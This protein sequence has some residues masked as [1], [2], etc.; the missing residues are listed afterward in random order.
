MK[1]WRRHSTYCISG[2]V[3]RQVFSKNPMHTF[4]EL[5]SLFFVSKFLLSLQFANTD[6]VDAPFFKNAKSSEMLR[7]I[8]FLHFCRSQSV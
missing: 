4:R 1:H 7:L 8:A 3:E 5:V 6:S 2:K